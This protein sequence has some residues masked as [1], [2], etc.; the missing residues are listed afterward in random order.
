MRARSYQQ[1]MCDN[2]IWV[3]KE[4]VGYAREEALPPERPGTNA[5]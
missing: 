2:A 5:S 4:I 3:L 1:R